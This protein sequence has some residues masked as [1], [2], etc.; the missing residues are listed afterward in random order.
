LGV[1]ARL[2]RNSETREWAIREGQRVLSEHVCVSHNYTYFYRYAM[3]SALA[4]GNW[5]EV[6]QF[7][8]CLEEYT[9][10]EPLPL[11][12][13]LVSRA[14]ALASFG[15]GQRSGDLMQKLRDLRDEA[16]LMDL[17]SIVPALQAALDA[18]T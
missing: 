5:A 3:E 16:K 10:P 15:R 8:S 13:L 17:K 4:A 14:R 2:T 18:A 12:N 9:R 6:E 11:C 7:A 1:L